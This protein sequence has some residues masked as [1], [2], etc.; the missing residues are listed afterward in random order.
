MF[1]RERGTQV[2]VLLEP[3][4]LVEERVLL[5]VAEVLLRLQDCLSWCCERLL[6]ITVDLLL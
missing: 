6:S 4:S 5:R 3:V 2:L 1:G